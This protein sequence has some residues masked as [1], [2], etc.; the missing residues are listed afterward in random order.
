[1]CL[2]CE[3][4]KPRDAFNLHPAGAGG[5][6]PRCRECRKLSRRRATPAAVHQA[7][8]QSLREQGLKFCGGCQSAKP[9][10]EFRKNKARRDGLASQCAACAD[11]RNAS[12]MAAKDPEELRAKAR[13]FYHRDLDRGRARGR[14]AAATRRAR[15]LD[16]F[17][18]AVDPRVVFER[19]GGVCG[20][21]SEPVDPGRFDV[22]HIVPLALGGEHSYPNVRVAHPSCNRRRGRLVATARA[23]ISNGDI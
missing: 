16:Q 22:D 13:E 18:E 8:C 10:A 9:F 21:C 14:K 7:W 23:T 2:G 20:I 5:L 4:Y 17:V 3:T 15:K 12:Y 6:Q 11:V 19:D 1:V